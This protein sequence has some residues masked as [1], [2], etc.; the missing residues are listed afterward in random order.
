MKFQR[1]SF[2]LRLQ[3]KSG[4]KRDRPGQE[5]EIVFVSL[6]IPLDCDEGVV[7]IIS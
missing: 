3:L 6:F 2:S 1:L 5:P 7:E 4:I